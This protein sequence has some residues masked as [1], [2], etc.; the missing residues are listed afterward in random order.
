MLYV[1][2]S[3]CNAFQNTVH[4]FESV[5]QGLGGENNS[6]LNFLFVWVS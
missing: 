3:L 5:E 4:I 2:T 6:I 1:L